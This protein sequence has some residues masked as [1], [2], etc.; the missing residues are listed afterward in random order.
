LAMAGSFFL[1]EI[2]AASM[3]PKLPRPVSHTKNT[4]IQRFA[5]A[6]YSMLAGE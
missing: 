4:A 2:I 1:S 6:A 3:I 5:R